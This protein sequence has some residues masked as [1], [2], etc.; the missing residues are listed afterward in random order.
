MS[1]ESEFSNDSLNEFEM[2]HRN[3]SNQQL[4]AFLLFKFKEIN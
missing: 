4:N 1:T 3:E 2:I